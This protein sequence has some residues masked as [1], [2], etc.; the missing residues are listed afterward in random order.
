[1]TQIPRNQH[2]IVR[3]ND[4]A[5]EEIGSSKA[6]QLADSFKLCQH[7]RRGTIKRQHRKVVKEGLCSL[8]AF[9]SAPD[10]VR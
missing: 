2:R 4:A 10:V 8:Q 6:P 3:E 1:M 9:L 5:D 7:A